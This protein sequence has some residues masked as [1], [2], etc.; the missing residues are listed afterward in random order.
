MDFIFPFECRDFLFFS[1]YGVFR[2]ILQYIR[3][4]EWNLFVLYI[5]TELNYSEGKCVLLL[6]DVIR[7]L[8]SIGGIVLVY[9]CKCC[10][11]IGYSTRYLFLDR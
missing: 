10:N 6:W 9:Y 1:R 11:L 7:D 8:C 4:A 5:K 3:T 2:D